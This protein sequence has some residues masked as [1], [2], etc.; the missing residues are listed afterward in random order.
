MKRARPLPGSRCLVSAPRR[1]LAARRLRRSTPQALAARP[2]PSL[3]LESPSAG[4]RAPSVLE[5]WAGAAATAAVKHPRPPQPPS[6]PHLIPPRGS[7]S[8]TAPY[9]R[10][11]ERSGA[12]GGSWSPAKATASPT[13]SPCRS[14]PSPPAPHF[15]SRPLRLEIPGEARCSPGSSSHTE[16]RARP[17]R[18]ARR[19]Q[20]GAGPALPAC[21]GCT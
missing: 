5:P 11:C 9:L 8:P 2:A 4:R 13:E 1:R 3:C 15:L 17:S 7:P 12:A 10:A 21:P 6:P 14:A 20:R 16:G 19:R 18:S